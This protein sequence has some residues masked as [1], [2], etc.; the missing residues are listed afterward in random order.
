GRV[1]GGD[2]DS[3]GPS[4]QRRT[5]V[6]RRPAPNEAAALAPENEGSRPGEAP[7]LPGTGGHARTTAPGQRPR[8]V[9]GLP[10]PPGIGR[11]TDVGDSL[12]RPLASATWLA[13]RSTS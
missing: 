7:T 9:I 11:N 12:S 1:A 6:C 3:R 13:T 4:V 8:S 5:P 10:R 2:D